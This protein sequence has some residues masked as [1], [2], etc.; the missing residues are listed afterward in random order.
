MIFFNVSRDIYSARSLLMQTLGIAGGSLILVFGLVCLFSGRAVRPIAKNIEQQK[1]FI[2]DA[3]HELKTP[4]TSIQASLDVIAME[5]GEDEWTENIR[6]QTGRM[7]KLVSELV[8]LSKLDEEMPLPNKENFSLSNAAWEIVEVYE[9][10]AKARGKKLTAEIEDNIRLFGEKTS[11][12]Q[13]LSVLLDN[14]LRYSDEK[15]EIRFSLRKKKNKAYFEIFNTCDFE[16]P[17]DCNRLFERFYRPDESRNTK[18][19]GTGVGMAIARAVAEAHGGSISA[20][21]PSGE[22]MTIKIL[23]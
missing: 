7:S 17:P 18:T 20:V 13:M 19:G 14:A 12:Q 1:Q 4:L 2:T 11:V 10:Q 21:C 8:T 9:P 22:S 16:T 15:S 5:H 23:L 6:K 3:S